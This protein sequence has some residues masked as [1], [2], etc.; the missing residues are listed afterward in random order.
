MVALTALFVTKF[1]PQTRELV[2]ACGN[3]KIPA[4]DGATAETRF[5]CRVCAQKIWRERLRAR[6]L[7][8]ATKPQPYIFHIAGSGE[9]TPESSAYV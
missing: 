1:G 8:R 9:E 7:E 5:T 3:A 4:P 6:I 2:C